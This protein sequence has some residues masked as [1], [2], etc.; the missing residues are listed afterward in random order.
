LALL[1]VYIGG[2]VALSHWSCCSSHVL[3]LLFSHWWCCFF[4]VG[5]IVIFTLMLNAQ[6]LIGPT[7]VV[8]PL[9]LVLLLF[10]WLVWYFCLLLPCVNQ[11]L[12][13]QTINR[14]WSEFCL[15]FV[16]FSHVWFSNFQ[17]SNFFNRIFLYFNIPI[18]F[19][20]KLHYILFCKCLG[21]RF[22]LV[23]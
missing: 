4:R 6:V 3:L 19:I 23:L 21:N 9:T 17:K 22:H 13:H 16:Y 5:V 20:T 11:N 1:F 14:P 10:P 7:F 18:H 2:V 15:F 8:V 12:E